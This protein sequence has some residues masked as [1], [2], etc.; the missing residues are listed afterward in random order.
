MP[1]RLKDLTGQSLGTLTVLRR[2][3]GH[4]HEAHWL[5]RCSACGVEKKVVGG[6]FRRGE[7]VCPCQGGHSQHGMTD[8]PLYKVWVGMRYRCGNARFLRYGG[9]GIRVCD[10]WAH[11]F[12]AFQAWALSNGWARGLQI[13]RIDNDGHY[14]PGNCRFVTNRENNRNKSTNFS[15]T[16]DGETRLLVEWSEHLGIPMR[17]LSNRIRTYGWTPERALATPHQS[18]AEAARSRARRQA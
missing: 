2:A 1:N 11:D 16:H 18:V 7:A 17:V 6:K 3:E 4:S 14:Q 5:C 13:D 15:I 8:T 9:R 12:S 10:E